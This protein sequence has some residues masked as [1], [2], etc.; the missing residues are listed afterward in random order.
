MPLKS[1]SNFWRTF[2][3]SQINCGINLISTWSPTY[4]IANAAANQNRTFVITDTKFYAPA[5]SLSTQI[6]R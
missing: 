6:S 2:E 1:L 5:V 3:I 4:I